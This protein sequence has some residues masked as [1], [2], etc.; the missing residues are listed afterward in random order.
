MNCSRVMKLLSAYVDGELT[1]AEMLEI[2]RHLS[3]CPECSE[4]HE[5]LLFMKRAVSRLRTVAPR[6][7]FMVELMS[8]LDVVRVSPYQKAMNSMM[9]F[10]HRRLSP[11]AAALAASGVALVIMSA[12]GMD[13]ITLNTDQEPSGAQYGVHSAAVS[14]LPEVHDNPAAIASSRPLM[15]ANDDVYYQDAKVE[16]ASFVVQR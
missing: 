6:Q 12:G 16:Y 4:E 3:Y 9:R 10:V 13:V 15:V 5:A 7:D 11:A 8:S 14:L 2:R 1:G